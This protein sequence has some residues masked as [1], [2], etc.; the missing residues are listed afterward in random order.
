[1]GKGKEK[2]RVE[3]KEIFQAQCISD[4]WSSL[5]SRSILPEQYWSTES[6]G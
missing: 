5:L 6:K 2:L 4:Y 3:G 1:L